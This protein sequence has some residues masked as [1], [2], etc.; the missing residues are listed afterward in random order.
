MQIEQLY[1]CL[2]DFEYD[3]FEKTVT[4]Y[5]INDLDQPFYII[6]IVSKEIIKNGKPLN[7]Y[8]NFKKLMKR[9]LI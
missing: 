9:V 6:T 7:D 5:F 8:D 4:F 3:P 1:K 2:K